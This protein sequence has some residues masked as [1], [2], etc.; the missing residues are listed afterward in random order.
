MISKL[1]QSFLK[2]PVGLFPLLVK[3]PQEFLMIAEE[4]CQAVYDSLPKARQFWLSEVVSIGRQQ[5]PQKLDILG[6]RDLAPEIFDFYSEIQ[7]LSEDDQAI[8]SRLVVALSFLVD[9]QR[10]KKGLPV[11]MLT[12]RE[13]LLLELGLPE[14]EPVRPWIHLCLSPVNPSTSARQQ[15]IFRSQDRELL[16]YFETTPRLDLPWVQMQKELF[17]SFPESKNVSDNLS[18]LSFVQ[19]ASTHEDYSH[20]NSLS[21]WRSFP[22]EQVFG[23]V[24]DILLY[25]DPDINTYELVVSGLSRLQDLQRSVIYLL[26]MRQELKL[27]PGRSLTLAQLPDMIHLVLIHK[28]QVHDVLLDCANSGLES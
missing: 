1:R 23:K 16:R 13:W 20:L 12:A 15:F 26:P 11:S 7:E 3:A 25:H 19:V 28:N 17:P 2:N 9:P 22:K 10:D 5:W 27:T 14:I 6:R 4:Y 18:S 8:L 24:L 21:L